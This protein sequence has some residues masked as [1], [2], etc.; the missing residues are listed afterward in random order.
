MT[1]IPIREACRLCGGKELRKFLHFDAVPLFDELVS[2]DD[3]GCE[4]SAPMDLFWCAA[5]GSAQILHDVDADAYYTDYRY[6]GSASDFIKA[7]MRQLASVAVERFSLRKGDRAIEIGAADGFFLACLRDLGMK[8]FGFEPA[9]NLASLASGYDVTVLPELFLPATLSKL[10]DSFETVQLVALLHTFDH[11][12]DPVPFLECV[13]QVLDPERGILVL[14]VHDLAAIVV[15]R[16]TSLFG[17]EHC[18]YL[19]LGSMQRLLTRCGFV[20]L[21][22]ELVP[23]SERRGT[24][25]LVAAGIAGCD[26]V[27]A[28]AVAGPI[29]SSLD[30][31]DSYREFGD[32]VTKGYRQL[33]EHVRRAVRDGKR[34]A[35]YGA[36][37]RGLTTLAMAGLTADD[38]SYVCDR[39]TS[40]HGMYT[41]ISQ[42]PVRGPDAVM[43][44][45]VDEVIVF[46]H[47]YMREIRE[48][49]SAF[50]STGGKLTSV[51]T[52]L[53]DDPSED[54]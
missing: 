36:W 35:G 27:P 6:V 22:A 42:I 32:A 37:G 54:L 5:C 44:D 14:E 30:H 8:V 18:T 10:P 49:L 34:V 26:H 46:C 28:E 11:L 24:S 4:F 12:P 3:R 39:N 50:V 29:R 38:L 25:M 7:F 1:G 51:L 33:A 40:L 20:L 23:Q 2:A 48:Q 52:L 21:D 16:E 47:G 13:R 31:W 19:H 41:P 15:N 45:S 43:E 17:H 9:G 53:G